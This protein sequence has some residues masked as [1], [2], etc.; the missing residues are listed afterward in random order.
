ME[1]NGY[2]HQLFEAVKALAFIS[3][4]AYW[5]NCQDCGSDMSDVCLECQHYQVCAANAEVQKA[6]S[7]LEDWNC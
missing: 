3:L 7:K 1:S 5:A 6:L 4:K 2:E